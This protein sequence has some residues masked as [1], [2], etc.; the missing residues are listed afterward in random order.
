MSEMIKK[1]LANVVQALTPT[2]KATAR[3]NIDAASTADIA[4]SKTDVAQGTGIIINETVGA[5]GQK[6]FTVNN[7][8]PNV[9]ADWNQANSNAEDY[10]KNKPQ[11]L[12]QDAN[13]VHTDNNFT[14]TLKT[15]LDGIAAG[16]EVNVQ[17]NWNETNSS[18]D[19]YIQNKPQNLVQ[20]A[21][22]VHTDNNF[23]NTLKTKL[24]GIASGAEV[25]VQ[26]D[27]TQTNTSADDYIK[28]KP[29][30]A[31]VATSGSY[32]DLTNKPSIPSSQVNSDWNASSGVAK[33]LNKPDLGLIQYGGT[34][35]G[36]SS[37][38]IDADDPEGYVGVN[39]NN[40]YVGSLVS[41]PYKGLLDSGI[42]SGSGV[43]DS[44]TPI[45]I[46]TDGTFKSGSSAVAFVS[47]SS[48]YASVVSLLG[49]GKEVILKVDVSS[50]LSQYFKLAQI[51]PDGSMEFTCVRGGTSVAA[52]YKYSLNSNSQW[53]RTDLGI[54][55]YSGTAPV[56]V[57]NWD[58]GLANGGIT[59]KKISNTMWRKLTASRYNEA[60]TEPSHTQRIRGSS[61][62]FDRIL[63][64]VWDEKSNSQFFMERSTE[65]GYASQYIH[66]DFSCDVRPYSSSYD[67][68]NDT[69]FDIALVCQNAGGSFSYLINSEQSQRFNMGTNF[70]GIHQIHATFDIES[71]KMP[72]SY[73]QNDP[74]LCI[75]FFARTNIN[76]AWYD[77]TDGLVFENQRIS[78]FCWG[79]R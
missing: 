77:T 14:N 37:L 51:N 67:P 2:E 60:Y 29:N 41:G 31:T 4:A 22:Y 52:I 27:W 17:A 46:D 48:S 58:I 79:D 61:S 11:N 45:Y 7:A 55:H 26:S 71:D 54:G 18:S 34:T 49:A 6:V 13:Y 20:D 30:L 38:K 65:Q 62:N 50:N 47:T 40:G 33:I 42:N 12:V 32:N 19:A 28:N 39:V 78:G 56:T 3:S 25:N 76:P 53:T 66:I 69:K 35:V 21:S 57:N 24:D 70:S 43:G 44:N 75:I 36:M 59:Y 74:E 68:T 16:A 8:K 9:Q 72:A 73:D 63:T 5:D 1:V 64:Y 15:K 10:I 23:T